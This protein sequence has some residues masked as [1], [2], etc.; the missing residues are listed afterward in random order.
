MTEIGNIAQRVINQTSELT[1]SPKPVAKLHADRM[2]LMMT[3]DSSGLTARDCRE[4]LEWSLTMPMSQPA[5]TN[6]EFAEIFEYLAI[7]PSRADDVESG[8]KRFSVYRSMLVG[9]SKDS[10]AF[11]A[12]EVFNRHKFFPSVSECIAILNEYREPATKRFQILALCQKSAQ[13]RFEQFIDDLGSP[14]QQ[15]W[16]DEFPEQWRRIAAERGFLRWSGDKL[17]Q[18]NQ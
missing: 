18:R 10:L 1:D 12:R 14:Q 11:M 7:M 8:R 2:D 13:A 9:R 16:I 4:L 3:K 5:A 6:E 17:V 15:D